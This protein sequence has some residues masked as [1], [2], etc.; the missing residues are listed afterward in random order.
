[1]NRLLD[2]L[3]KRI[4]RRGT[5]DVT[6]SSGETSRYGEA[7]ASGNRPPLRIVLADPD[8][9]R[10]LVINP[11]MRLGE[12]Y[13]DGRLRIENGG[14]YELLELLLTNAG[15]TKP[16]AVLKA[17]GHLRTAWRRLRRND[18]RRARRNVAHHYDLDGRLYRLFLDADLQYSCAYFEDEEAT[19]DEAQRAKKRHLAAKLAPRPGQRI[20]D[21]GSGWGGLGLYLAEAAGV[22]VTGVTLST[23]QQAVSTERAKGQGLDDRVRFRLQDYRT[24]EGTFDRIVSVGMFE[25]VGLRHY[26]EFFGTCRRLLKDD[27]V[28]V[29]H[30]IGR[31]GV[32]RG[33]NPWIDRYIF[34]GHYIPAL[35]EVIAATETAGLIVTDMEI[36]RLH[37][38]ETLRHWRE[39]FLR[40]RD[41]AAKLYDERFCRMWEFY[42]AG[43]ELAF[44]LQDMMVFQLQ[45][46]KDQNVLPLTRDHMFEAEERLRRADA[47]TA[48]LRL[49]GE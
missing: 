28:M 18:P 35:S 42:L 36:L 29:L 47:E 48:P 23:E 46:A 33:V 3:L 10:G 32:P 34:P 25:H 5:L 15:T 39:R 45:L 16:T 43:C 11:E 1:M 2:N 31:F 8:T 22:D 27:G 26:G 30:S 14:A 44:R 12:A 40:R 4:V 7:P 6:W 21:I 13:M 24:V 9:E 37:Y 41:E 38:A 49:A 17:A 20:L 19:L